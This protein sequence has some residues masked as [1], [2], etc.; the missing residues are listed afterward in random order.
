MTAE[1]QRSFVADDGAAI[2]YR[3]RRPGAPRRTL[4]L[5]HGLASN[6]TRWSEFVATTRL[7]ESWDILRLDLRGHGGSLWRGRIG[8]D[9]WCADLAGLLQ[10]EGVPQAVLVGH[11]LGA[12]AAMHFAHR[13]PGTVAGLVLIEPM[14][15]QALR[16]PL[17]RVAA[18]RPLLA[19][20]APVLRGMAALG[21]HRRHLEQLDLAALDREARAAM[22]RAGGTFPEQRYASPWQDLRSLP[23][24]A[25]C[26]DLL[27]VT[28]PLPALPMLQVPVLAILSTGAA[29]SDPQLTAHLL[30]PLPDCRTVRFEA[31]HW[32]PTE[33]PEAMRDAIEAW[34]G[35]RFGQPASPMQQGRP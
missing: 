19:V 32:I 20:L 27:A 23:V 35:G 13:S 3:L 22:L 5:L 11:C 6:L 7:A 28:A 15:R 10:A 26:Q 2:A 33:Q 30:S 8:I 34:C 31:R 18:L 25:Y 12:N 14:F 4:V 21:L 16:G 9:A 1:V 24:S 29:F 17:A